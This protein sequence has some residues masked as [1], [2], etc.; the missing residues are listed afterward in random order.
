M[1]MMFRAFKIPEK[2]ATVFVSSIAPRLSK[3]PWV[4][5]FTPAQVFPLGPLK[6]FSRTKGPLG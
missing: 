5:I 6:E 3:W 1:F 4:E 2:A